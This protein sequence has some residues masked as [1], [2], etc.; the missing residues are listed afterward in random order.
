[1][2]QKYVYKF[3]N[4]WKWCF[5]FLFNIAFGLAVLNGCQNNNW[6]YKSHKNKYTEMKGTDTQ[7]GILVQKP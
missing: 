6:I 4:D 5:F 3:I 7:S 2:K 1:M